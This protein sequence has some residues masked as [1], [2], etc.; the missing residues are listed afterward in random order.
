MWL[1]AHPT[2]LSRIITTS[3]GRQKSRHYNRDV[4]TNNS[5][6][7]VE[8]IWRDYIP[9]LEPGTSPHMRTGGALS[10]SK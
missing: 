1:E 4:L 9:L 5:T 2:P 6:S 10:P 3:T 7:M 8:G